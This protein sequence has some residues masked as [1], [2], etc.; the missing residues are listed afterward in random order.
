MWI[1][2]KTG[3]NRGFN[4]TLVNDMLRTVKGKDIIKLKELVSTKDD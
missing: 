1:T 4:V 2:F 3:I